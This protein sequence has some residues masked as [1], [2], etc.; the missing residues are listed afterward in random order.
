M[1]SRP[2]AGFSFTEL[3]VVIA[4]VTT[5]GAL[6]LPLIGESLSAYQLE[7]TARQLVSELNLARSLSMSRSHSYNI[8]FSSGDGSYQIVD[9]DD[10]D[11]PPRPPQILASDCQFASLP[12]HSITFFSAGHARSGT[13]VIENDYGRTV[14]IVVNASGYVRVN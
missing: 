9:P 11:N 8:Q 12:D 10:S 5:L 13:V 3:I 7:S 1:F 2:A 6:G 14:S 4:I